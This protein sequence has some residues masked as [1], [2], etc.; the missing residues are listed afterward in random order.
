MELE[1]D[2]LV[3]GIVEKIENM[4]VFVKLPEGLRGTI[5][6]SE[7]APGRIKNIREYVAPNKIIVCKVL[8]L[9]GNHIDL[10]LRRVSSKEKQEVMLKYQEE[11][12]F[13]MGLKSILK[14]DY[15]EAIEKIK[16]D[17][18]SL[19]DFI[20]KITTNEEV[21]ENYIP[22]EH[23]E[24]IRKLTEKRKK[25]VEVKKIIKLK[26]LDSDGLCKIR[27]IFNSDKPEIKKTYVSAGNYLITVKAEDYK[28]ANA[29]M[30][31][32]LDQVEKRSKK[33][34]CEIS[35]EDKK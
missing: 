4:N 23:L 19:N 9:S 3:L 30:Q 13:E 2:S 11:K 35:I 28:K 25:E 21:L 12:D 27:E 6:S 14:D 22:K 20:E 17:F 33:S 31:E 1:E 32:F 34:T 29:T 10:S 8:R 18:K 15:S 16:R 24:N 26:C 5:V 7:I